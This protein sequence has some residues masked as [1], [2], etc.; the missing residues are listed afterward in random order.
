MTDFDGK[1]YVAVYDQ[2]K[3]TQMKVYLP[4]NPVI[5]SADQELMIL[6]MQCRLVQETTTC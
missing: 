5:I 2:F 1:E 6:T 3:V 4:D